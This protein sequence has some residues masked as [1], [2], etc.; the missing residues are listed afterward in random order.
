MFL[1]QCK[2]IL[3]IRNIFLNQNSRIC[4]SATLCKHRTRKG[5]IYSYEQYLK[6][7]KHIARA[8]HPWIPKEAPTGIYIDN[9]WQEIA[10]MRPEIV[11]PKDLDTCKLRPYVEWKADLNT[12][13]KLTPR[14]L[15]DDTYGKE[16]TESYSSNRTEFDYFV[17]HNQSH[18][19]K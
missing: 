5:F 12:V 11:V 1:M 3:A 7:Q 4:T 19:P 10:E 13:D 6:K 17:K 18:N 9:E 16:M 8:E 15:F 2:G 14:Q